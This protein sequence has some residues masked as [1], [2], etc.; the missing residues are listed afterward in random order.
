L[1]AL[2]N[3]KSFE[4]KGIISLLCILAHD[5]EGGVEEMMANN[6]IPMLAQQNSLLGLMMLWPIVIFNILLLC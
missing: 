1:D 2:R 5:I 3:L 4:F 6:R